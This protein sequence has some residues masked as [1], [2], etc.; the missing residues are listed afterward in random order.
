MILLEQEAS[1]DIPEMVALGTS[2]PRE[3][4]RGGKWQRLGPRFADKDDEEYQTDVTVPPSVVDVILNATS[5]VYDS[6]FPRNIGL[7]DDVVTCITDFKHDPSGKP[8]DKPIAELSKSEP[9]ES[10]ETFKKK[11]RRV[12]N[13]MNKFVQMTMLAAPLHEG[14]EAQAERAHKMCGA[15]T[16]YNTKGAARLYCGRRDCPYCY[17][18]RYRHLAMRIREFAKEHKCKFHWI[19]I[20]AEEHGKIVRKIRREG[21]DYVCFPFWSETDGATEFIASNAIVGHPL[22]LDHPR[23]ESTLQIWSRTPAGRKIS[24][25]KGFRV[26]KPKGEKAVNFVARIPVAA[27]IPHA[28]E[29]GGEIEYVGRSYVKWR[30]VKP[31]KLTDHLLEKKIPAYQ[32]T[33]TPLFPKS[34]PVTDE[35]KLDRQEKTWKEEYDIISTK[36]ATAKV[37]KSTVRQLNLLTPEIAKLS[38]ISES[39]Y[40][41]VLH[42]SGAQ[43]NNSG[44]FSAAPPG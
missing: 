31:D 9:T 23:L 6:D 19:R 3:G 7:V 28:L 43:G 27:I 2:K 25:S 14:N 16:L 26:I 13:G 37:P 4:V 5:V 12:V 30:K 1:E 24:L 38:H 41:T 35:V 11:S 21:G 42:N 10:P 32:H 22:H 18:R 20:K 44:K 39:S 17:K 34:D 29:V 15:F 8:V 36:S 40:G 33:Y